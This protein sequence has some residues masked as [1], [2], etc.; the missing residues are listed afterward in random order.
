[1]MTDSAAL[2]S[3]AKLGYIPEG[4][5]VDEALVRFGIG[6]FQSYYGQLE[7]SGDIDEATKERLQQP[8]C[9]FRDRES[10][11]GQRSVRERIK[12]VGN[13]LFI[14]RSVRIESESAGI[15][16]KPWPNV[17]KPFTLLYELGSGVGS[18]R[19]EALKS[20]M[21]RWTEVPDSK[22]DKNIVSFAPAS[23]GAIAHIRFEWVD[24]SDDVPDSDANY[25]A[26]ACLPLKCSLPMPV[27][28]NS[29]KSWWADVGVNSKR[30]SVEAVAVHEIG[31]TLGLSHPR[32][33][34][35]AENPI[36]DF[37]LLEGEQPDL[38]PSD[39]K[40]LQDLYPD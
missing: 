1:M 35:L 7:V 15:D 19:K 6:E 32:V 18:D 34:D 27:R 5:L 14:L 17:V 25:I 40:A 8:R 3:L 33:R 28:F 12:F 24:F 11:V 9:G 29:D 2:R 21:N 39:I 30:F 10:I 16:P 20:A 37:E 36:M 23:K 13:R 4:D 38:K 26:D 31:H 22:G